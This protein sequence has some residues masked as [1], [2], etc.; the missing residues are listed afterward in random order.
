M[1]LYICNRKNKVEHCYEACFCG[2][3]HMPEGCTKEEKCYIESKKGT[4]VKCRPLNK[5]EEV[6]FKDYVDTL[7]DKLIQGTVA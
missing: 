6:T 2:V 3:P 4:T 1:K 7:N 5:K